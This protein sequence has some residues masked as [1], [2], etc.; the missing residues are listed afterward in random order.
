MPENRVKELVRLLSQSKI[1]LS[2]S[3]DEK[4]LSGIDV[5]LLASKVI[6]ARMGSTAALNIVTLE[7]IL[8]VLDSLKV[9]KAP[10]PIEVI[11]SADFRP[12]AAETEAKYRMFNTPSERT[13]GTASDFV[14]HFNSRLKK[15]RALIETR[16]DYGLIPNLEATKGFMNGREV[17]IVGMVSNKI[18]TKKG[19]LM[20][21]LEDET[22]EAKVMIMNGTSQQARELFE[23]AGNLIFDEVVAVKG[24]ISGP[25][26]IA[27]DLIW[28]D[29]PIK[30]RKEVDEDV[31]IAFMSDIHVGSKRF[32]KESFSNVIRWLNGNI[33]ANRDVAGKIKYIVMA[34]DVVDGVGI[35]P[36]QEAELAIPDIY[37]QY[38]ELMSFVDAIPEY[39]HV[40][41]LPGNHDAVQLAEPQPPLTS[42]LLKDFRKDNVHILSN[43][44]NVTLHG[45]DVLAYHGKSL[46]SIISMV[47]GL[48][49]AQP[50][51]AMIEL[52]K[53]RHVSPVYG[54]A[55][56]STIVPSK[57][58]NLVIERIP[59]I[60]HMGH[61]HKNGITNYHGV[62]VVNSG[63]WQS[64]TDFQIRQ[65]HIPT[66]CVLPVYDMKNHI[67]NSINFNSGA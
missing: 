35:Y 31:S 7:E 38:E 56:S 40:F 42:D 14:S 32:M 3:I 15:I 21:I 63:T 11:R 46:D 23:K 51:K 60:L 17:S 12:I 8:K 13:E 1:V 29:I 50:E 52:L 18:E 24:K 2:G 43:P 62:E 16:R 4:A 26:V 58:D 45:M 9:E 41:M 47:P 27:N 39:I 59:D 66:P 36:G 5:E 6:E 28:P 19:N 49:Y 44:G 53:R 48:S 55:A 67:F 20:I 65:G 57:E 54:N 64:R 30:Q 22:G 25:F 61:V 33:E 34:G 10:V 37:A